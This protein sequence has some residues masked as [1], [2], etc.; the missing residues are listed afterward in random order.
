MIQ[1]HTTEP[2]FIWYRTD[3]GSGGQVIYCSVSKKY[4][5]QVTL[6]LHSSTAT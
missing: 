6:I 3:A 1:Q 5:R 4:D 2:V